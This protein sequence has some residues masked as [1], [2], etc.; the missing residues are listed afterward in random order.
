VRA[1]G[2]SLWRLAT[3]P[4]K[5]PRRQRTVRLLP[6]FDQYLLGYKSRDFAVPPEYQKRVF[7]GGEMAPVVLV[8]GLAAGTWRYER[9]GGQTRI[10]ATPFA[11]F[12]R[13]VRDLIAEEADDIAR[14]YGSSAAL[15]FTRQG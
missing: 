14:F 13:E 8:D 6:A 10:A 4:G 15:R 2:R 9:R 3:S 5:A 1:A 11:S 12:T 7:H